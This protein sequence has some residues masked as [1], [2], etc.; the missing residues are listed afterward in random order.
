VKD[1][2]HEWTAVALV[3]GWAL[4]KSTAPRLMPGR[5]PLPVA[6]HQKLLYKGRWPRLWYRWWSRIADFNCEAVLQR[7]KATRRGFI[8]VL[9]LLH[10]SRNILEEPTVAAAKSLSCL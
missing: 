5:Q 6:F 4:A 2:V 1:R 9:K 7:V 3:S 10:G 8:E